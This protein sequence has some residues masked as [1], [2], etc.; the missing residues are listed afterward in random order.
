MALSSLL[1]PILP[2]ILIPE[3]VQA[4][5]NSVSAMMDNIYKR[6]NV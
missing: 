5:S 2:Q 3:M 4:E 6:Q 1:A